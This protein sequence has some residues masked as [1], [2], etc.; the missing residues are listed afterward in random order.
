ML[1]SIPKEFLASM[2]SQKSEP[3]FN[4]SIAH[5]FFEDHSFAN[6]TISLSEDQMYGLRNWLAA[7]R[8]LVAGDAGEGFIIYWFPLTCRIPDDTCDSCCR[9]E[10]L[11]IVDY[12]NLFG[13]RHCY[14]HLMMDYMYGSAILPDKYFQPENIF[15]DEIVHNGMTV[16]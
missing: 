15:L 2:I 14:L 16:N 8:Q 3:T 7:A 6:K 4:I 10:N 11:D 9:H 13:K 5:W 1:T 12:Y